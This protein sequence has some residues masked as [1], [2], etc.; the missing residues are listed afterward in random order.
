MTITVEQ[1]LAQLTEE[2]AAL[3]LS[4]RRAEEEVRTCVTRMKL[5]SYRLSVI[6]VASTTLAGLAPVAA[7]QEWLDNLTAWRKGLCDELLALPPRIRTDKELGAQQNLKLSIT[8]IDRGPG[9]INGTG[10]DLTTLRLGQLMREAGYAPEGADPNRNFAG[11]MPWM[12]SLPEIEGRIARRQK[13]LDDAQAQLDEALDDTERARGEA[14]AKA[15][16]DA[17]NAAPQR[18]VREDGSEYDRYPDGR[19]VEVTA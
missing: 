5:L 1:R 18:K 14:E 10:Y 8:T 19:V 12:G 6:Q 11:V 2:F 3:D 4:R 15:R 16:R 9:V 13:E 17:L 7:E